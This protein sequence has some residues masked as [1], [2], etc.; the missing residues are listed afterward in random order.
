MLMTKKLKSKNIKKSRNRINIISNYILMFL[1][2]IPLS[3]WDL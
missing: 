1:K 3:Q 2:K